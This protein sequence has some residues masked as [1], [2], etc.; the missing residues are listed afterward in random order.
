MN[1]KVRFPA[2]MAFRVDDDTKR[3][4]EDVAR[5]QGVSAGVLCRSMILREVGATSALPRSQRIVVDPAEL[6]ML[7]G[8]LGRQGSNLNQVARRLNVGEVPASAMADLAAMRQAYEAALAG[9]TA[10]LGIGHS[11]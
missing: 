7:L 8:E 9:I 5:A 6:R 2:V 4:I 3:L 11:P 10:A 1:D